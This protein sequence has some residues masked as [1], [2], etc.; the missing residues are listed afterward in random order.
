MLLWDRLIFRQS[1]TNKWHNYRVTCF[2]I[3]T[4]GRLSFKYRGMLWEPSFTTQKMFV[5]QEQLVYILWNHISTRDTTHEEITGTTLYL[6]QSMC[7][8]KRHITDT[9]KGDRKWN[10][11][12][13][14]NKKLK[15]L[16]QLV[17]RVLLRFKK[18]FRL[19]G[20]FDFSGNCSL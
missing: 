13:V 10:P 20:M 4:Y 19:E 5:K 17:G 3:C 9:F 18:W 15:V 11:T 7:Q 1:I 2:K 6:L 8:I 16:R 14:I 12:Q